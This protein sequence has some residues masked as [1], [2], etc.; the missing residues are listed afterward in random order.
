MTCCPS[1]AARRAVM[2]DL[3][4]HPDARGSGLA[5]AL[6]EE[7]RVRARRGGAASMGW[8]TAK[9][10]LRAQRVY[11]RVGNRRA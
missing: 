6:I 7:C 9:D 4:V 11:E 2:N 8:Q 5:E 3:F 10:T 1:S